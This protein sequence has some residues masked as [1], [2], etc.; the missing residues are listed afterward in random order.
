MIFHFH[1]R[2]RNGW[3]SYHC[4]QK[5]SMENQT[6]YRST[7]SRMNQLYQPSSS[8]RLSP[9]TDW[10][11][12]SC[13]EKMRFGKLV[14]SSVPNQNTQPFWNVFVSVKNTRS[15]VKFSL[16]FV[17][18]FILTPL[19]LYNRIVPFLPFR[20]CNSDFDKDSIHPHF[21][22]S[23]YR[24]NLQ[25][26]FPLSPTSCRPVGLVSSPSNTW[27]RLGICGLRQGE[28]SQRPVPDV[29]WNHQ[30]NRSFPIFIL[31]SCFRSNEPSCFNRGILGNTLGIGLPYHWW[32]LCPLDQSNLLWRNLQR[33]SVFVVLLDIIHPPHLN[34]T[35]S[36]GIRP[37][38]SRSSSSQES[39]NLLPCTKMRYQP[40]Q[41]QSHV[42][43]TN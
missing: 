15:K 40:T 38:R 8:S 12:S 7:W 16:M 24:S 17:S 39:T 41:T 5:K 19:F 34:I 11:S 4:L 13:S 3:Q 43:N 25:H 35:Q 22:Y 29:H 42:T 36:S 26:R 23:N 32:P 33:V 30:R 9:L 10:R 37:R 6:V 2:R 18:N 28:K 20:S 21:N 1:Q 27:D 31:T 14:P